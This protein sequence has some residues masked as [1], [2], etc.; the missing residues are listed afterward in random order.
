LAAE[1]S[2]L[3]SVREDAIQ[4]LGSAMTSELSQRCA[5]TLASLARQETDPG[6]QGRI[7]AAWA[8]HPDPDL[9]GWILDRLEASGPGLRGEM[10]LAM[11]TRP[12]R[13]VRLITALERGTLTAASLDAV[14][15]QR[16]GQIASGEAKERFDRWM[17]NR[18]QS[19][20]QQV[21]DRYASALSGKPDL[22]RGKALFQQHCSACH[23]VDGVGI[24]LGPDI[25]DSRTQSPMQLLVA[26]LDPNRAV[27]NNYFRTMVRME[28]GTVH[29]GIAVEESAQHLTLR[30]PTA[31]LLVLAKSEI[32]S[33]KGT[34]VSLMPE[35][36]EAQIDDGA[37]ADLVGY[38]KNWRYAG[39]EAPKIRIDSANLR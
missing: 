8:K 3:R 17:A 5:K 26:I 29:D 30:S 18:I 9:E 6:F 28:D 36:I 35:G 27:D 38:L 1:S 39:G 7:L 12:E 37:M 16:L 23:R 15:I 25:S 21:I 10:F 24:A 20:R 22:I 31:G 33:M 11:I 19:D 13:V 32:E 14:Q 34:G 2:Y 4:L